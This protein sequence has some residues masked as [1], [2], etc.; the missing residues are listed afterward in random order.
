LIELL[1]PVASK[2]KLDERVQIVSSQLRGV[3][4]LRSHHGGLNRRR[5]QPAV[6]ALETR[7]L[8]AT[9]VSSL[10]VTPAILAP[11]NNRYR[12]VRISGTVI[13]SNAKATPGAAF[14]VIDEYRLIQPSGRVK[15]T[16]TQP[17]VYTFSFTVTLQ[18]Q[19]AGS[20]PNGRLYNVIVGAQDDQGSQGLAVSALVPANNAYAKT[21]SVSVSEAHL[22]RP[23][24]YG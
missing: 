6:S 16:K 13:E 3:S 7:E 18:A 10:I 8:A 15:L 5:F 2:K 21:S 22:Q 4:E 14:H 12:K 23:R 24:S 1:R 17:T 11:A 9:A 19:R 20:D